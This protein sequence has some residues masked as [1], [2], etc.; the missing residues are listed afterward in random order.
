M[1][2]ASSWI[3]RAFSGCTKSVEVCALERHFCPASSRQA[4]LADELETQSLASTRN[5]VG[6]KRQRQED[7]EEV[8]LRGRRFLL[9]SQVSRWHVCVC[10]KRR[11][12]L[13]CELRHQGNEPQHGIFSSRTAADASA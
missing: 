11:S 6:K 9:L 4:G 5:R 8:R 3:L 1:S 12:G 13:A 2:C 10:Q 7:E